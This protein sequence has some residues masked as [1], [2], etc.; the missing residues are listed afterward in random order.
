MDL[1]D[2][3]SMTDNS[4]MG[5]SGQDYP[6]FGRD[7]C[8]ETRIYNLPYEHITPEPNQAALPRPSAGRTHPP[9]YSSHLGDTQYATLQSVGGSLNS[10]SQELHSE[11]SSAGKGFHQ[12]MGVV[13]GAPPA[14]MSQ[15][16]AFPYEVPSRDS[17]EAPVFGVSNPPSREHIYQSVGDSPRPAPPA[18]GP[19]PA[20]SSASSLTM[21]SWPTSASNSREGSEDPQ[22]NTLPK[23]RQGPAAEQWS[24]V[25]GMCWC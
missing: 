9:P 7:P 19:H 13:R 10:Q 12:G 22:L 18:H 1:D 3:E 16:G 14:V 17:S 11:P 4:E 2:I 25:N 21:P 23:R 15:S 5:A 6:Q 8:D 24:P 20:A